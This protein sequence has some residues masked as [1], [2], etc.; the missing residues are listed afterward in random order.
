MPVELI[1]PMEE[2]PPGIPFT[3]QLMAVFEV[4]LTVAMKSTELPSKTVA[5]AGVTFTEMDGGGGVGEKEEDAPP[6][7]DI[8]LIRQ[9]N[10]NPRSRRWRISESG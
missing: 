5:E 2:L 9:P 8:V 1:A 3:A 6:P 7:Q 4:P 10:P